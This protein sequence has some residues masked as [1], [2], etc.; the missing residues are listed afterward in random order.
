MGTSED[1]DDVVQQ[2][3]TVEVAEKA[4]SV[5]QDA[6]KFEKEQE[7]EKKAPEDTEVR[8]EETKE[9][10]QIKITKTRID[11]DEVNVSDEEEPL[12]TE[13]KER[14][15]INKMMISSVR[16]WKDSKRQ[17]EAEA[18]AMSKRTEDSEAAKVKRTKRP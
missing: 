5:L 14:M 10:E 4:D 13:E 12:E 15:D 17:A 9:A 6:E 2:S 3:P 16:S 18:E 8:I 7:E 1:G 11:T